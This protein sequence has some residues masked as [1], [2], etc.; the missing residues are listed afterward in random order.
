MIALPYAL[1]GRLVLGSGSPRRRELL[2]VLGIPYT[3]RTSDADE[4]APAHLSDIETVRYV[5]RAKAEA[6]LA[7]KA[8]D[9]VLLTADTEVWF[10]GRRFGKPR[11]LDHAMEMLQTLRGQTHKVITAV[12]AT[13]GT[14]WSQYESIAE[15][16][17][18]QVDDAFIHYYV[19]RF[20]PLDK[21]GAYGAQEWFG[22]L[23][24]ERISGTFDNVKGLPLDTVV[25]ALEPWL[26]KA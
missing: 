24:I 26:A 9:E 7:D 3:V 21:A 22:Q 18:H 12:C 16:T 10:E 1:N 23:A 14:T 8:S 2:A 11:D 15:V 20:Q 19:H 13:D 5:A 4:S 17:F 25:R 6:L